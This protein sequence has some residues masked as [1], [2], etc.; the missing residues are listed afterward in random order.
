MLKSWLRNWHTTLCFS[1]FIFQ[2][3]PHTSLLRL[4]AMNLLPLI[5][6][7]ASWSLFFLFQ[8]LLCK[9][10]KKC[11]RATRGLCHELNECTILYCPP[12]LVTPSGE[13]L[14]HLKGRK[15]RPAHVAL[16]L[17]SAHGL[18]QALKRR[19]Q[20][21]RIWERNQHEILRC[22]KL[23]LLSIHINKTLEW[24]QCLLFKETQS[25]FLL[26]CWTFLFFLKKIKAVIISNRNQVI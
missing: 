3:P 15:K 11:T 9:K 7:T 18:S 24:R 8:H 26:D 17:F 1:T 6:P 14:N 10:S 23:T 16:D 25:C 20:L 2:L 21:C 5:K 22:Y 12:R 4:P 13:P 19:L